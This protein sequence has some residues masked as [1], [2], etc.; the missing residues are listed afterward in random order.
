MA[1]RGAYTNVIDSTMTFDEYVEFSGIEPGTPEYIELQSAY[2][3]AQASSISVDVDFTAIKEYLANAKNA[4]AVD[5]ALENLNTKYASSDLEVSVAN[6]VSDPNTIVLR[7]IN[8]NI[9]SIYYMDYGE[10]PIGTPYPGLSTGY[11]IAT[12]TS[13]N[14]GI[15][16]FE[17]GVETP[18]GA[19]VQ[20][21]IGS[22]SSA[23]LSVACLSAFAKN[24][25]GELYEK[26]KQIWGKDMYEFDPD[27]W[28]ALY[29]GRLTTGFRAFIA[30]NL[31]AVDPDTDSVTLYVDDRFASAVA[32]YLNKKGWF[33]S[34]E[35]VYTVE[36][37]EVSTVGINY[38]VH[39]FDKLQ[40]MYNSTSSID[41]VPFKR[42]DASTYHING[43][44]KFIVLK[45]DTNVAD[46]F[47]YEL[48]YVSPVNDL[49]DNAVSS[50]S[51]WY[52]HFPFLPAP[53]VH[54]LHED[55][56][57]TNTTVYEREINGKTI[58][59]AQ[60]AD[61]S[62]D[63]GPDV[64]IDVL[65]DWE[66]LYAVKTVSV[67][68]FTTNIRIAKAAYIALYGSLNTPDAPEG[69]SDQEGKT[70]LETTNRN[71]SPSEFRQILPVTFPEM[72]KQRLTRGVLQND[73][74]VVTR[75]YVPVPIPNGSTMTSPRPTTGTATQT[76]IHT[77]IDTLP[78][79]SQ[80]TISNS[81]STTT[82]TST[83]PSTG[84]KGTTLP[85]IPPKGTA[86]SMWS[87]YN[88]SQSEL[89][90]FG[91]WMW[92]SNLFEQIAKLFN[93]PMQAIIGIHKVFCSPSIGGRKSIKVGYIDSGVESNYV[94]NQYTTVNCGSVSLS[95]Y[96]GNVFDYAP[97]TNVKLYLPFVG[98]VN[99]DVADV[100]R[101]TITVEYGIDVFTGD[102]LAKVIVNRDGVGGVLY[103]YPGNCAVKY[104]YSSGSYLGI[105]GFGASAVLSLMTGVPLFTSPAGGLSTPHGGSFAGNSGATGPK[106]PYL[107]VSRPE[108]A[109]ARNFNS[110]EGYPV[111][112]TAKISD[113][114]GYIRVKECHLSGINATD[115]ELDMIDQILRDGI[116]VQS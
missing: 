74:S 49:A 42:V 107:V 99:L 50:D 23:I 8:G 67:P 65:N 22:A 114:R 87:V 71:L 68:D 80:K 113:C 84:D 4:E 9:I 11:Q 72:W 27:W 102:C 14:E 16:G 82:N 93:D 7:D 51:A 48:I 91:A 66:Q 45:K 1:E 30:E 115:D 97:F 18:T 28:D 54:Y 47:T 83:R 36:Q 21:L 40:V 17:R 37:G 101:S 59:I 116:I 76:N 105:L 44:G 20:G 94:S 12:S 69:V 58:Y 79:S 75:T 106:I 33:D 43:K 98:V 78:K 52:L 85:L 70:R 46:K 109:V 63:T 2:K 104:P 73:G 53:E 25:R 41:G 39:A 96:F 88:P 13:Q 35:N 111:N 86:S 26:S 112:F 95:E 15:I 32:A 31:L 60:I 62:L 110:F 81:V 89:N 108:S 103:S 19:T 92:S 77:K 56:L 55:N 10:I 61:V 5:A 6:W 64:F 57:G 38:P 90:S 100:M 34:G 3:S 29:A 24:I